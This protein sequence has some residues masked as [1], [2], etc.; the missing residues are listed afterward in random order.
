MRLTDVTE[1]AY[2]QDRD[3]RQRYPVDVIQ[4]QEDSPKTREFRVTPRDQ[5]PV[6][7]TY[8]LIVDGL[9]DASSD[10]PLS[11]P[12]VFPVGTTTPLKIEW[13]GAY[14]RPL[15][16]PMIEIKFNDQ[17]DPS[18]VTPDQIRIEP[19]VQNLKLLADGQMV[20]AKGDFD[21]AQHYVVTVSPELKGQRGYGLPLQSKWGATF[22]SKDPCIVFASPELYLRALKELRFSFLQ[23][24]TGPLQ[25]K[26]ARIPLE[27]LGAVKARLSE[28][29][30]QQINPLTGKAVVDPRT[31]FPQMRPTD[32]LIE[33]F[34]LPVVSSGTLDASNDDAET[35][36]EIRCV[37]SDGQSFSG[38][39]LLEA[40]STVAG[41]R[42]VGNRSI[43]LVSNYILTQKRTADSVI[44]RITGMADAQPVAGVAVRAVTAENIELQRATTD[45][46]GIATLSRAEL[47]PDQQS[48]AALII[49]DT[50]ARSGRSFLGHQYGIYIGK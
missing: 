41:G 3:S 39:Y 9:T 28:F 18:N 36:R 34:D 21:L 6:S 43:I 22:H 14:N 23:I 33:T 15:E 17:F 1:H 50:V 49:A 7:R 2:F 5:L 12:R 44:L 27:K 48:H 24:N 11:Y 30:E 37:S 10:D 13:I 16:E 8:D 25:W 38:P 31:G 20:T 29:E 19:A 47:F 35:M 46:N 4:N 42:I 32:L 40:N 26:L 45:K